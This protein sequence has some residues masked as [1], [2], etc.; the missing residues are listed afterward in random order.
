MTI[1]AIIEV[2][3]CPLD[4]QPLRQQGDWLLTADGRRRYPMADGIA[5]LLPDKAQERDESGQWQPR[6]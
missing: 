3:R 5:E 1:A 2:L 4:G 6:L